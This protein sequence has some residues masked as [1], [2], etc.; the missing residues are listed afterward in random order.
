[1]RQHGPVPP[2]V[3]AGIALL[4]AAAPAAVVVA[5][6]TPAAAASC[7]VMRVD[8]ALPSGRVLEV[9]PPRVSIRYGGCVQFTNNTIGRVTVT[10][11]GGYRSELGPGETTPADEA[12]V[13]RRSGRQRVTASSGPTSADG[14]ITVGQR[15]ASATPSPSPSRRSH[16]SPTAAG[17]SGR[18]P[19]SSSPAP[20]GANPGPAPAPA[21]GTPE[22]SVAPRPSASAP[23][24]AVPSPSLPP[25]P[26]AAPSPVALGG[27]EPPSRRGTGLPAA[28]AAL[29]V[30]GT[31][32]ALVRVLLA[33]SAAVD[34]RSTVRG[35][36]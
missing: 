32:A 1:M 30:A 33:E 4:V 24:L 15:P 12:F 3:R 21:P 7:A 27:I 19:P 29:V 20:A 22:R 28:V 26:T 8:Y 9:S 11:T 25:A 2:T 23:V 36:A 17:S 35:G 34:N 16:P 31:G 5:A 14:T 13:G 10:V 18:E 6:S